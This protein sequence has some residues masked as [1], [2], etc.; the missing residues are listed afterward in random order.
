MQRTWKEK[1]PTMKRFEP[2]TLLSLK[3]K[4]EPSRKQATSVAMRYQKFKI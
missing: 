2:F 4:L 1:R 3:G